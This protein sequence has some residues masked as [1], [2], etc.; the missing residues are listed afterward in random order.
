[1][2]TTR[3]EVSRALRDVWA[4]KEA[5]HRDLVGLPVTRMLH[6][7]STQADEAA[8]RQGFGATTGAKGG[9]LAVAE[10]G[11]EYGRGGG[12]VEGRGLRGRAAVNRMGTTE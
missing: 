11:V 9:R 6:A 4:W 2:T 5:L 3:R 10:G 8:R 7:L 12:K 1:M